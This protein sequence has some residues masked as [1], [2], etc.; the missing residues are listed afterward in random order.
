MIDLPI[1]PESVSRDDVRKAEHR[2]RHAPLVGML[3]RG[4]LLQD[5]RALVAWWKLVEQEKVSQNMAAWRALG[6]K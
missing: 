1:P 4:A 3:E 6:W 5:T 2:L